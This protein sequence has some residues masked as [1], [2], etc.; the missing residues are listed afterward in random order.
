MCE[1]MCEGIGGCQPRTFSPASSILFSTCGCRT[2]H[3]QPPTRGPRR[4]I[5]GVGAVHALGGVMSQ[6]RCGLYPEARPNPSRAIALRVKMVETQYVW[7]KA[8]YVNGRNPK[9][10]RVPSSRPLSALQ[11]Q[12]CGPLPRTESPRST[13]C[14]V[15]YATPSPPATP[16]TPT[17]V[18]SGFLRR[19]GW[20]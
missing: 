5:A 17:V 13:P 2:A 20:W 18:P 16:D 8:K 11:R 3:Y 9:S 1:V 10:R 12:G 6:A 15:A 7:S 4:C 19:V 14:A